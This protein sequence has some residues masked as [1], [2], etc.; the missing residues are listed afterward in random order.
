[1]NNLTSYQTIQLLNAFC[2]FP[3]NKIINLKGEQI[4]FSPYLTSKTCDYIHHHLIK[5]DHKRQKEFYSEKQVLTTAFIE[6]TI[7]NYDFR[8]LGYR[9]NDYRI[10]FV[11]LFNPKSSNEYYHFV[12]CNLHKDNF[13]LIWTHFLTSKKYVE[14]H[15]EEEKKLISQMGF[16]LSNGNLSFDYGAYMGLKGRS[17][18]YL[19][20]GAMS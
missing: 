12:S 6:N 7:S 16:Y 19:G 18:L 10:Y 9:Q 1:M 8:I 17:P 11:K 14:N 5:D 20:N 15:I 3:L 13:L 4:R 2:K